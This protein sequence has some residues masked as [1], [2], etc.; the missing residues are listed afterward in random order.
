[1][2]ESASYIVTLNNDAT[3]T[4]TAPNWLQAGAVAVKKYLADHPGYD[5]PQLT[6]KDIAPDGPCHDLITWE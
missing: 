1:M 4:V 3:V 2:T 6:V 5:G